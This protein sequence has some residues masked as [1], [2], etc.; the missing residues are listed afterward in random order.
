MFS[1][2]LSRNKLEFD[3]SKVE[4]PKNLQS[5]DLNHNRILGTADSNLQFF[6]VR[7]NRLCVEIPMGGKLQSFDYSSYFHNNIQVL[8]WGA[9]TKLQ[10]RPT[11]VINQ[12]PQKS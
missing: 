6:N 12:L 10:V 9:A 2:D 11:C 3:L 8:M 7:Y 4:I 5:L 1:V